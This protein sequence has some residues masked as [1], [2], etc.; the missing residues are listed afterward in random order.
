MNSSIPGGKDSRSQNPYSMQCPGK[1]EESTRVIGRMAVGTRK[2]KESKTTR[3][4]GEGSEGYLFLRKGP[5]ACTTHVA[6]LRVRKKRT[7]EKGG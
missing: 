5:V 3:R 7:S 4:K 1:K 2:L 6:Q